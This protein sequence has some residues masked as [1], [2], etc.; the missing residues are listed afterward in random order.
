MVAL[1]KDTKMFKFIQLLFVISAALQFYVSYQELQ[2]KEGQPCYD[3]FNKQKYSET[4]DIC[5]PLS[6][7]G[8][9]G[10]SLILGKMY[11]EGLG[12]PKNFDEARVRLLKALSSDNRDV[13]NLAK[14]ILALLFQNTNFTEFNLEKSF[15]WYK[16]AA[17]NGHADAQFMTSG[18]LFI[19]KGVKI[20]NELAEFYLRKAAGN[21]HK[22]AK[23]LL[24]LM[25]KQ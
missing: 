13:S 8:D 5:I 24:S 1:K 25:E 12:V 11:Y 14:F 10:A 6:N 4:I 9:A 7:N 17:D 16:S 23:E 3:A 15:N 22:K 18:W 2:E 20:D 19:G 21:G